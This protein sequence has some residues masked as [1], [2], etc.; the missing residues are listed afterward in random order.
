VPGAGT[1]VRELKDGTE[2][3]VLAAAQEDPRHIAVGSDSVYWACGFG[4]AVY[5]LP[6]AGGSPVVVGNSAAPSAVVA[7][8]DY[9]YWTD[10]GANA[11]Y[12]VP[13]DGG[14]SVTTAIPTDSPTN[15]IATDA[16]HIYIG[17][18]LSLYRIR[19]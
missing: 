2:R 18:D 10:S 14:G 15:A 11:F 7:A 9:V 6:L 1:V 13:R 3:V 5:R 19:K 12:R 17:S 4:Q 8:G 16:T